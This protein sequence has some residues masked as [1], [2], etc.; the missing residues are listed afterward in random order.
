V[1]ADWVL[2]A[3]VYHV[4]SGYVTAPPAAVVS[5]GTYQQNT[6][7]AM[8]DG[9]PST[10]YSSDGP[11]TVDD[12]VGVDLG[13]VREIGVVLVQQGTPQSTGD[14]IR[15]GVVECSVDGAT[16]TQIGT[17]TGPLVRAVPPPGTQARYVRLRATADNDDHWVAVREFTVSAPR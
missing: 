5:L 12:A 4:R 13:D 8:V 1:I 14:Y 17:G 11:V 9:D 6:P 15:A 7:A 16:W 3:F 2:D 10:A